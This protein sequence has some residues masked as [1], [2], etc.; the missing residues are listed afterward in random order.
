MLLEIL[1]FVGNRALIAPKRSGVF[2][3]PNYRNPL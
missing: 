2:I 1:V 3:K